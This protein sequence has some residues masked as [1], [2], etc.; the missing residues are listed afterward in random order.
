MGPE[1]HLGFVGWSAWWITMDYYGSPWITMDCHY[2]LLYFF[3]SQYGNDRAL[4]HDWVGK[5]HDIPL[6]ILLDRFVINH[7]K[8]NNGQGHQLYGFG[9]PQIGAFFGPEGWFIRTCD[10][11]ITSLVGGLKYIFYS[12]PTWEDSIGIA[13]GIRSSCQPMVFRSGT[14]TTIRWFIFVNLKIEL[15]F[16]GN[17]RRTDLWY[18]LVVQNSMGRCCL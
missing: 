6:C 3:L 11:V 13:F 14:T 17:V 15:E 2:G 16:C 1:N 7:V 4:G 10:L 8:R 18:G 12:Y 5:S 9:V